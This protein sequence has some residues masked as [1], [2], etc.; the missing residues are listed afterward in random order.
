MPIT[1]F[2]QKDLQANTEGGNSAV[3]AFSP[4]ARLVALALADHAVALREVK[5]G[6]VIATL[7]HGQKVTALRFSPDGKLLATAAFDIA[8]VWETEHGREMISPIRHRAPIDELAITADNRLLVAGKAGQTVQI[9]PLTNGEGAQPQVLNVNTSLPELSG[10][11]DALAVSPDGKYVATSWRM[12]PVVWE[13]TS[14][15]LVAPASRKN[16]HNRHPQALAFSPDGETFASAGQDEAVHVF[17]TASGRE[18]FALPQYG[19]V[20]LV[21]YSPRGTYLATA[22]GD[23]AARVWETTEGHRLK[24][25]VVQ[26]A[27]ITALTFAPDEASFATA[28]EDNTARIWDLGTGQEGLRIIHQKPVRA[29]AFSPDGAS[30]ATAGDDGMVSMWETKTGPELAHH[31]EP[32]GASSFRFSGDGRVVATMIEDK[33]TL[34]EPTTGIPIVLPG[35]KEDMHFALTDDLGLAAAADGETAMVWDVKSRKLTAT[36]KHDPPIDWA[37]VLGRPEIEHSRGLRP[38]IEKLRDRGSVEVVAFSPDGHLLLTRRFEDEGRVWDALTGAEKWRFKNFTPRKLASFSP[39]GELLAIAEGDGV[40]IFDAQTGKEL[41]AIPQ[42]VGTFDAAAGIQAGDVDHLAFSANHRLVA[43]GF[44]SLLF[45]DEKGSKIADRKFDDAITQFVCSP[46][47]GLV[48]TAHYGGAVRVWNA[49]DGSNIDTLQARG[50]IRCLAF[51]PDGTLLAIGGDDF[52]ARVREPRQQ[53]DLAAFRHL[54]AVLS[55]AFSADGKL[56]A[57]GS[58]DETSRVWDIRGNEAVAVINHPARLSRDRPRVCAVAL[59]PD[60]RY[61]VTVTGEQ[62]GRACLWPLHPDDLIQQA[63]ARITRALSSEE[64]NALDKS[65]VISSYP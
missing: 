47:S 13:T 15:R 9:L 6:R 64:R 28:S 7:P 40:R 35:S 62:S 19:D 46:T 1:H 43:A 3:A 44:R 31:A 63:A 29:F 65:D 42:A 59:S 10:G 5:T 25:T 37:A 55:V 8:H 38:G 58:Q 22:S 12:D 2:T 18:L 17:E 39:D 14:G 49:E 53:R 33:G 21:A 27:P 24:T 20:T 57:T 41:A 32:D 60:S 48:T 51:S 23:L 34:W 50:E 30:I 52:T 54:D 26:E 11:V 56:L 61:L 45:W 4:D 16:S 36:L